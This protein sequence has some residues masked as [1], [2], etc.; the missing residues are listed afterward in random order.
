M[1]QFGGSEIGGNGEVGRLK[2]PQKS[3]WVD[4]GG[5]KEGE[6]LKTPFT[7]FTGTEEYG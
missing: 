5:F 7:R 6:I 2:F 3:H 1:T 4:C